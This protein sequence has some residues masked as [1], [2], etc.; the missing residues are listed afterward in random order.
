[1]AVGSELS[2]EPTEVASPPT[3]TAL[4]ANNRQPA[5]AV[6][7]S[8][9]MTQCEL[10]V[11]RDTHCGPCEQFW[12]GGGPVL[13][14]LK[15]GPSPV[16]GQTGLQVLG[17]Q[18]DYGTFNGIALEGGLWLNP[19][20]TF[21]VTLGGMILEQRSTF[22]GLLSSPTGFPQITRPIFDVQTF[23]PVDVLVSSPGAFSGGLLRAAS[24]R[25]A[26][27]NAGFIANV[28]HS[29]DWSLGA[30]FGFRYLDL[31]EDLD[32]IQTTQA[33]QGGG[34]T[35]AGNPVAALAIEDRFRTRN[36]FY[37]GQLGVGG[38]YRWGPAFASLRTTVA[39]GPN[40][41][42]IEIA[43]QTSEIGGS[44]VAP[45]GLLAAGLLGGPLGGN[46][47]RQVTNRFTVVPEVNGRLGAQL[48][49]Y[50]RVWVGYTFLYVNDVARPG[51]Q[52]DANI[53][54]RVVP[55]SPAFG[56]TSG[57]PAPRPTVVRNDFYAHGVQ[58]GL[59]LRY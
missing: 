21:G 45:G 8:S 59:E 12:F 47:G 5:P 6:A 24:A 2:Q 30:L 32:V 50:L 58:F 48:A 31:E 56:S 17:G 11:F 16:L 49:S 25:L 7:C 27:G 13:W 20:H 41:E 42:V 43:G 15:D 19:S 23:Q 37:G 35:I 22:D 14:W 52:I 38:E 10:P 51:P 40:H 55:T 34:L 54:P 26:S 53:N 36:Q 1:L 33:L 46:M 29:P 3:A 39:L 18:Y 44:Q 4:A 28:I 57:L 9:E